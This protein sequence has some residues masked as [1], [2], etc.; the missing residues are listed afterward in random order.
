MP[1]KKA[2]Q[3]PCPIGKH[4]MPDGKC[5]RDDDPRMKKSSGYKPG[6]API[7]RSSGY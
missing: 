5:M 2:P 1:E 7:K 6:G 3:K 4:R